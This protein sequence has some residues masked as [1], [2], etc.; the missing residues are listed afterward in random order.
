MNTST[1]KDIANTNDIKVLVDSFYEKI[2]TDG[3]IGFIFTD[4]A[5]TNWEKHLPVMYRFWENLLF[6]TGGYEGNPMELHQ[7]LHRFSNLQPAYF[8]RWI[9][10]FTATVDQHFK[11]KTAELAKQRAHS[12]AAVMK[13]KLF[14][15]STKETQ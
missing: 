3:C 15:S 9:E 13:I 4:M 6:Y 8:D 10:L 7:N 1:K 14:P 11:G 2:K 12:I 5:K